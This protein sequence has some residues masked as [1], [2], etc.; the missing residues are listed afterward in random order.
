[1]A[2]LCEGDNEPPGSLKAIVLMLCS[3]RPGNPNYPLAPKNKVDVMGISEVR[4]ENSGELMSDE[5]GLFYSNDEEMEGKMAYIEI[6]LCPLPSTI[7]HLQW[8]DLSF[9][10]DDIEHS[11]F[12]GGNGV[13]D[14]RTMLFYHKARTDGLK[15]LEMDPVYL[16]ENFQDRLDYLYY[17]KVDYQPRGQG[18]VEG[19]KRN[20]L[21]LYGR[22]LIKIDISL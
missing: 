5:F 20:V 14:K 12:V 11:Y 21:V 7:E 18:Q 2:G 8:R 22:K 9:V 15:K 1:M 16:I 17:R 4:W 3:R 6:K 19:P 10:C 13:E